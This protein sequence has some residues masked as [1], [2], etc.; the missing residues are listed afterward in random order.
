MSAS[1]RVLK[2]ALLGVLVS[3]MLLGV[4][5]ASTQANRWSFDCGTPD[6]PLAEGYQRLT[7]EDT[8][9]K[10][11]GYG[12]EGATPSSALFEI[13]PPPPG[14]GYIGRPQK[15]TQY[16]K[17]SLDDL[18]SDAVVSTDDLVFRIDVPVATYRV[19]LTMGDMSQPIGSMDV[20]MNGDLVAEQVGVWTPGSYAVPM[21][22]P[23][24]WWTRVR[25]TVE[26][27]EQTIR[28]VLK[29]NQTYYDQQLA[30]QSSWENPYMKHWHWAPSHGREMNPPWHYIGWPFVQNS[31]MAIDIVPYVE[32]PLVGEGGKLRL[33]RAVDSPP[34]AKAVSLFNGGNTTRAVEALQGVTEPGAQVA[35]AIIALWLVA[36]LETELTQENALMPMAL[37]VLR[38]HVAAHPEETGVAELLQDAEIFEKAR[39]IHLTRGRLSIIDAKAV[40]KNH[41]VENDKAIGLWWMIRQGS[42]L[43]YKSRLYAARAEHMLEPFIPTLGTAAEVFKK[44]AKEFPDSRYVKYHLEFQWERSGD[45][46][47]PED[48]YLPDYS[49]RAEHAPEWV[50]TLYPAMAHLIDFSEWWMTFKQQPEGNIGGGW[51]DDVEI[52]G[53]FGYMGYLSRG[54][55]DLSIEG[56]RRLV[57]GLW[58]LSEVDPETGYCLP[59]ADAEHTAEWTGNTLGMMVQ[60]DYGNPTWIERSMKTAKLMRDLWTDYDDAGHRRFRANYFSAAQVGTG[61]QMNDSWIS[62]RAIRP[63]ASVLS[64][65]Q[66]PAISTLFIELADSWLAVAMSTDRGKPRGVIPDNIA[67]R[68]GFIGGHLSPNWYTAFNDQHSQNSDWARQGYKAYIQDLLM[69]AFEQTGDSKYLEPLRLEY[70]LAVRYG[71]MP[72]GK[73]GARL[74]VTPLD[75]LDVDDRGGSSIVVEKLLPLRAA[76][77]GESKAPHEAKPA[78]PAQTPA[79]EPGGEEWVAMKLK[80]IEAWLRA[81]RVMEGRKDRLENDITKSDVILKSA[82]TDEMLKLRWPLM[83]T[84]SGPTDRIAFVGFINPFLIATGGWIG[85]PLIEAAVTYENTTKHFA[86]VVLG[87]DRQGIRLLYHSLADGPREIGI[88]PWQLEPGGM[89]LLRYAPDA[90]E[91]E[92]MDSAPVERSFLWPQRGTPIRLV[93]NPATTYLIEVEQV[94][95]GRRPGPAPDPGL[96]AED[97]RYDDRYGLILARIHNVGSKAVRNVQVAAYEGEVGAEGVLIGEVVIPN[98]E[99]PNDL[100]PRTVTVGFNWNAG[101]EPKEIYIV[102]DP[103]DEIQ[104][105][106]TTFNDVAHAR[107]PNM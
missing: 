71:N 17:D 37:D 58:N 24:G 3:M 52:A 88:V 33:A 106:I 77:V 84:E 45:G 5:S 55:S 47:K 98:I 22:N 42:P 62:Y 4:A 65:N 96:S 43:Y 35:R 19:S 9:T 107:L 32:P 81:K 27:N 41:F 74:Q 90:N 53:A 67:F 40:Q 91:D 18:N 68:D 51:G 100:E 10:A 11:K 29:K 31:V 59:F 73:T 28:I 21:F 101:E 30:E 105:E 61:V 2:G 36:R 57:D 97:I 20:Y 7:P 86:A 82:F 87:A 70:E 78:A 69:T 103:D 104:D 1:M 63:A 39:T 56:T 72:A 15:L 14:V 26:A 23:A 13:P 93:V 102:V 89:Y 25:G 99:A 76:H 12:W 95:R 48:W 79:A 16:F 60:L 80:G 6:S 54:V 64:Y 46:T 50:R 75:S 38:A 94:E 83:T 8:Y 66:N 49:A 85:G 34:L 92:A 44:L